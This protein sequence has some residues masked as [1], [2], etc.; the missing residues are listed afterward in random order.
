MRPGASSWGGR[1]ARAEGRRGGRFAQQREPEMPLGRRGGG[2]GTERGAWQ[3]V[4][5]ARHASSGVW[6]RQNRPLART[7]SFPAALPLRRARGDPRARCRRATASRFIPAARTPGQP[8]RTGPPASKPS[9]KQPLQQSNIIS[10]PRHARIRERLPP[11]TASA[12][13]SAPSLSPR[14][15]GRFPLLCVPHAQ[16]KRSSRG[17][18]Q[19]PGSCRPAAR[20]TM[21][22]QPSQREFLQQRSR[23]AGQNQRWMGRGSWDRKPLVQTCAAPRM[24]PPALP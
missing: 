9:G 19:S 12:S 3:M 17:R 15:G 16:W 6:H 24:P 11:R 20:S 2:A 22:K 23:E 21:K 4:P 13:L 18:G 14:S 10:H 1:R 8:P 5:L 7:H